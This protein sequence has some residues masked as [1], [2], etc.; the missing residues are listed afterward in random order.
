LHFK[1]NIKLKGSYSFGYLFLYLQ[2][3]NERYRAKRV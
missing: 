2:G 1:P 3:R